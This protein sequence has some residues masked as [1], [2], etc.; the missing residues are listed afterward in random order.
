MVETLKQASSETEAIT[1]RVDDQAIGWVTFDR[2]G[3]KVNVLSSGVMRRLDEVIGELQD[4]ESSGKIRSAV[5]RSGKPGTF[6]A[7]AD[8]NEIAAITEPAEGAAAARAGQQVFNRLN[9]LPIPTIAAID[10]ICLG[11]GT[12]LALACTY[13]IA[14]DRKET[15]IG[16]PEV[17]LGIIPGFGGTTR[18]PRLVGMRAALEIILTGRPIDARKAERIGLVD[19]RL[20]PAILQRRSAE[21][22]KSLQGKRTVERAVKGGLSARLM[23]S[24]AGR[25]VMLSQARKKTLA[26]TRG[27]YPA[28]LTALNLLERTLSLSVE[29]SLAREAEAI[30]R[31]IV[32]PVSKNLVH[33]F[34]LTEQ[35]KKGAPAV[36]P[37]PVER[38]GVLGAG[39]MG[40]GIAQILA[41]RGLLVRLKDIKPD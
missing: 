18:L 27:H 11:G 16:L 30:G 15:K 25:K 13:R 26:E 2:P 32:T 6:I 39:V 41:Y 21:V 40:G 22:A 29:A 10:G 35:A 8:V 34:H 31:L 33:V 12:E 14:T 19:E 17:Q 5:I 7:G 24:P 4:A 36:K 9:A 28:P 3:A 20:H 37:R 1:L 23:E 38:V